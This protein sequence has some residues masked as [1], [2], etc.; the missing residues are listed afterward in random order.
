MT[1]SN[2]YTGQLP[3]GVY[4]KNTHIK[5]CCHLNGHATNAIILPTDSPFVML[6]SNNHLCQLV[7][8]KKVR[9][10]YF[11][12]D[13]EDW[14]PRTSAGGCRPYVYVGKNVKIEYCYDDE[15]IGG[16]GSLLLILN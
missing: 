5:Y 16:N 8:G 10:E 2:K 13:C 11:H 3:D 7:K 9:S 4:D 1:N 15:R 14:F 12:W 6:K